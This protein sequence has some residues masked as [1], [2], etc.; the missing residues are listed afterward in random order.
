MKKE[1]IK[2][3]IS[4]IIT[5]LFIVMFSF[6]SSI[7]F[8]WHTLGVS[9]VGFLIYFHIKKETK[10]FILRYVLFTM[11][12][13]VCGLLYLPTYF[14]FGG[15]ILYLMWMFGLISKQTILHPRKTLQYLNDKFTLFVLITQLKQAK[16]IIKDKDRLYHYCLNF[17]LFERI[18]RLKDNVEQYE[19][20]GF[21]YVTH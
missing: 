13:C 15:M 17:N 20:E 16:R 3:I 18:D 5:I 12:I 7:G 2:T 21:R 9:F 6:L 1:T 8:Y 19:K 14:F 4:L 11:W 10:V